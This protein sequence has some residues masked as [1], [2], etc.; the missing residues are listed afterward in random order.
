MKMTVEFSIIAAMEYDEPGRKALM[1][2]GHD[3]VEIQLAQAMM[4]EI[5]SCI[6]G[7]GDYVTTCACSITAPDDLFQEAQAEEPEDNFY[8]KRFTEGG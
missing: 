7:A 6:L 8:M 3:I 5:N 4:D 1:E 2:Q